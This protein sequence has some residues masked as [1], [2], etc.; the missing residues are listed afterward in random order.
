MITQSDVA[1]LDAT[2]K[3]LLIDGEWVPALVE[4]TFDTV[5]PSTG[6]TIASIIPWNSPLAASVWKIAPAEEA[7]LAPLRLGEL[8]RELDLPPG[9]VNIVT[10]YG[11]TAGAAPATHSDVDKIDFTGS[12]ATGQEIIRASAVNTKRVHLELNGKS[13]GHRAGPPC[14]LRFTSRSGVG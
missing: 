6:A 10:G 11:E 7:S 8:L 12:T 14:D 1:I 3:R 2:P 9:V 4:K 13:P 5:N